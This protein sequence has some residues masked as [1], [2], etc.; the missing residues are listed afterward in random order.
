MMA[1]GTT[2]VAAQAGVPQVVVPQV[3]DQH[4][5]AKRVYELGIGTAHASGAPTVESLTEALHRTLNPEIA[6]HARAVAASIRTDGAEVAARLL[7]D[8]A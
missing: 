7:I 2:T 5:W 3:Y 6:A 4:Y 8:E 1:R